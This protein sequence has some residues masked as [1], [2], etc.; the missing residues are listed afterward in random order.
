MQKIEKKHFYRDLQEQL[1]PLLHVNEANLDFLIVI[2]ISQGS[3]NKYHSETIINANR[4]FE[5]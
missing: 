2:I 4:M 5:E 3:G 1:H